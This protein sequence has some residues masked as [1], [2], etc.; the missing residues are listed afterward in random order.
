MQ[1][2]GS[3]KALS[4]K[5]INRHLVRIRAVYSWAVGEER[6]TGTIAA[7]LC[8]VK[9]VQPGERGVKESKAR[10][11]AFWDDVQKVLP[12]CPPPVA[13]ML[14]LQWLTGMRSGEVRIVLPTG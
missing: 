4:R 10:P 3:R 6:I 2:L 7:A 1:V 8:E 5:V 12:H 9:G 13:A 11:P 14:Q